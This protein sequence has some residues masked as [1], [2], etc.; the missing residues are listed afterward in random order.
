[1]NKILALLNKLKYLLKRKPMITL[2]SLTT[3][4]LAYPATSLL[5]KLREHLIEI[6]K[7]KIWVQELLLDTS[8][9]A[10]LTS[11]FLLSVSIY[12]IC[13]QFKFIK[14]NEMANAIIERQENLIERMVGYFNKNSKDNRNGNTA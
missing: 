10:I 3:A 8:L 13:N 5:L 11:L 7:R 2:F 14:G 9:C 4:L 1:M 6:I 12:L